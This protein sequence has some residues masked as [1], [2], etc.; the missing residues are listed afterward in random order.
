M[1][2]SCEASTGMGWTAVT[3][4]AVFQAC[5]SSILAVFCKQQHYMPGNWLTLHYTTEDCITT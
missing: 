4:C 3:W 5:S 2:S 1:R